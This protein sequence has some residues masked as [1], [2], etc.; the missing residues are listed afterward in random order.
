MFTELENTIV[1]SC[2]C[3]CWNSNV[4]HIA[5]VKWR[6]HLGMCFIS[7]LYYSALLVVFFS[8]SLYLSYLS[9]M[10]IIIHNTSLNSILQSLTWNFDETQAILNWVYSISMISY[11]IHGCSNILSSIEHICRFVHLWNMRTVWKLARKHEILPIIP[12]FLRLDSDILHEICMYRVVNSF[13]A[14]KFLRLNSG[15][16]KKH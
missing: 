9:G 3:V 2:V 1:I 10:N 11:D 4:S 16:K 6:F 14:Y 12:F 13:L 15:N 5:Y 8:L 7:F